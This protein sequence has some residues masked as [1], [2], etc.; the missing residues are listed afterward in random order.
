MPR[1]HNG[2][3]AVRERD[4]VERGAALSERLRRKPVSAHRR[5]PVRAM[6]GVDPSILGRDR[7]PDQRFG[8]NTASATIRQHLKLRRLEQLGRA[9]IGDIL[10]VEDFAHVENA[11]STSNSNTATRGP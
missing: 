11:S 6:N 4:S 2:S 7:V 8:G 10:A 5:D 9:A 3:V 1:R